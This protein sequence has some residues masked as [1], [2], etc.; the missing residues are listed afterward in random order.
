MVPVV[1]LARDEVQSPLAGW[2]ARSTLGAALYRAGKHEEAV[3][4]L[5]KATQLRQA[6]KAPFD[7]LFLAM[8]QHRMG[9]TGDARK[10]LERAVEMIEQNPPGDWMER[11]ELRLLRGE[12]E[13]ILQGKPPEP[14]K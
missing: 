9:A 2:Q 3:V 6:G 1:T 14:K 12:V 13:A 7:F 10:A 11:L 4:E 8:A 5:T